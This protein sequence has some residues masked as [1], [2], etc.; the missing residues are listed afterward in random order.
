MSELGTSDL[1]HYNLF[2]TF[3]DPACAATAVEALHA[4]HLDDNRLSLSRRSEN[5]YVD[6]AIMRDELE[7][8]GPGTLPDPDVQSIVGV[9]T[10][11]RQEVLNAESVL[12]QLEPLRL[13]RIGPEGTVISTEVTGL[14]SIPVQPGSG[15]HEEL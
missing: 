5:R 13:D 7:G 3:P 12:L 15:R 4:G 10:D 2:A 6:E 8:T 1:G 9:H 11:R 14:D